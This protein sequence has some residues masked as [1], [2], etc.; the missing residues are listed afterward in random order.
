MIQILVKRILSYNHVI[1]AFKIIYLVKESLV[2]HVIFAFEIIYCFSVFLSSSNPFSVSPSVPT[3]NVPRA[4]AKPARAV[5]ILS[6]NDSATKKKTAPKPAW[7]S[8][9]DDVCND[10]EPVVDKENIEEFVSQDVD[11]GDQTF[12]DVIDDAGRISNW[13]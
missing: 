1:F 4:S 7:F 5:P 3:P 8:A 12:E 11:M 13:F 2:N 6:T 10:V 9:T